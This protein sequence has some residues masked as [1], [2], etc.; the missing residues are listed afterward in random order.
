[1]CGIS[2]IFNFNNFPVKDYNIKKINDSISHRGYD[3]SKILIGSKDSSF[4][5]YCGISI[6]HRRLSIID[7]SENGDQPMFNSSKKLCIVYNGEIYNAQ[8]LRKRFIGLGYKFK[9]KCDTEVI[10]AGYEILG[11]KILN[12]LNGM[13]SFAI[14]N[15]SEKSLFCARDPF[16]VKPFYY[17]FDNNKFIFSSESRA[18]N[19]VLNKRINDDAYRSYLMMNYVPGELSIF[20]RIKKLNKGTYIKIFADGKFTKKKYWNL[21]DEILK[22]DYSFDESS[23]LIESKLKNSIKYQ[24]TSDVP[25]GIFLSGGFDSGL[26]TALSKDYMDKINTYTV[27]FDDKNQISEAEIAYQ[28]S[29]KYSTNHH[30]RQINSNEIISLLDQTLKS[31]NEPVADS[32]IVPS[33]FLSK[34]AAEDGVKVILSGTGGDEIFAG[35]ERYYGFNFKRNLFNKTPNFIKKI[36]SNF[37]INNILTKKR[38][39]TK[40]LDLILSTG[41][42]SNILPQLFSSTNEFKSFI[43][44]FLN[45]FIPQIDSD[46]PDLY[47]KMKFDLDLYLPDSLLSFL[48]Q[49]TMANTIEGRVPYL[50]KELVTSSFGINHKYHLFNDDNRRIQKSISKNRIISQTFIQKKQVFQV[51]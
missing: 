28:L 19:S 18:I 5:T 4:S 37:F 13:F 10:I 6:A 42:S 43:E 39:K 44:K 24:L 29:L 51:L 38:F 3:S 16:G 36:L 46:L 27:S 17:Y 7:L 31:L 20:D 49:V 23:K 2:G 47:S 41:G 26:I 40:T 45:N 15:E 1:M 9:S 48:D 30:E 34:C 33:Y 12:E 21:N 22:T 32:A 14:W 50:D 35:Y 25:V 8:V 11:E